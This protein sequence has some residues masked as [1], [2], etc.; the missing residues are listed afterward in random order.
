MP[1]QINTTQSAGLAPEL[2]TFYDRNLLERLLPL[3]VFP[4][5]G[6]VR[7]MP[8]K[9]GQTVNYR[10]FNSLS[11]ATT[12]LTEGVTPGNEQPTIS[13]VTASPAQYGSWLQVTDLVDFTSPDPVLTEFGRLLAEQAAETFDEIVRDKIVVGTTVQ[14]AAG[15]AGRANVTSAGLINV[16]ECRKAVRTLMVNRVKKVTQ[17][18][19]ASTGVGTVPIPA[20]YIGI[21]GPQTIYDLKGDSKFVPVEQYGSS[22]GLLPNEVGKLDDIRF[23]RTDKPKIFSAAGSGGID[24]HATLIM[25]SDAY[26][27][28]AP[29]GIENIIKGFGAGDDPLNQR[30][31]SGWKGYFTAVI[32]QQLAIL[33]LEHAVSA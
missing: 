30:A 27:V 18:L 21:V 32:L 28:I 1:T 11:A 26:G 29:M 6:Q 17:I 33:R 3:L 15:V 13:T 24:V 2:R 19:N 8:S 4:L 31:S 5:F 14:Y 22:D 10:R 16:T 12:P 9:S 25:G 23:V 20:S 7:P